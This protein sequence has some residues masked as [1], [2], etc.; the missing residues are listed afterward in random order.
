MLHDNFLIHN[1]IRIGRTSS[2][3]DLVDTILDNLTYN[4][5]PFCVVHIEQ[6]L[7]MRAKSKMKKK[8]KSN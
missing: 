8:K 6:L 4:N 3:F 7:K 1:Y 5:Y 2:C